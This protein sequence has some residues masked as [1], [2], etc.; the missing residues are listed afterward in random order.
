MILFGAW[1]RY[2]LAAGHLTQDRH[3]ASYASVGEVIEEMG[4]NGV[5]L[6]NV[7]A[8]RDA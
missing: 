8:L 7:R 2:Q 6:A 5:H 3:A 1:L 4:D